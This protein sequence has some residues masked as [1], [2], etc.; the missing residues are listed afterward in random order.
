MLRGLCSL[1]FS[2]R[3][4]PFRLVPPGLLS[5]LCSASRTVQV[6]VAFL[7]SVYLAS[8]AELTGQAGREAVSL[9]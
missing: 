4:V 3:A 6:C 5:R 9:L 7:L 2:L 1:P 8:L